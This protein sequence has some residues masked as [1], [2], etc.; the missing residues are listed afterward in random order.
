[1]KASL[2]QRDKDGRMLGAI[3][4]RM[5]HS[6]LGNGRGSAPMGNDALGNSPVRLRAVKAVHTRSMRM[7]QEDKL[8]S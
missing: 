4:S 8:S 5:F 6:A 1:M 7:G 3:E 2:V